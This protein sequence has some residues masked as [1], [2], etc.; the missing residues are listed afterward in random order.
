MM[1][2]KKE[3]KKI[4]EKKEEKESSMLDRRLYVT[5]RKVPEN[6]VFEVASKSLE[7]F[8][9]SS[10]RSRPFLIVRHRLS[11]ANADGPLSTY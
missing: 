11:R 7:R 5:L 9:I 4:I 10:V 6:D 3:K 1:E 2:R 8:E